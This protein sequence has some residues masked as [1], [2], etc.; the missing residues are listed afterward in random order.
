MCAKTKQVYLNWSKR[1]KETPGGGHPSHEAHSLRLKKCVEIALRCV[2]RDRHNR[3][4]TKDVVDELKQLE[5][6]IIKRL[7]QP[8]APADDECQHK[9]VTTAQ[10]RMITL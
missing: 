7:P 1:L 3:P 2:V 10:V 4:S 6:E 9:H 5:A 8:Q